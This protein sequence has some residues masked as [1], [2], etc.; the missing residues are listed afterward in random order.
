MGE[1]VGL[2]TGSEPQPA[3]S[4]AVVAIPGPLTP[5]PS[6]ASIFA[7]QA[8]LHARHGG[9]QLGDRHIMAQLPSIDMNP[10]THHYP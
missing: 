6:M 1:A 7:C 3:S 4:P 9:T 5:A 10:P 2:C 8:G